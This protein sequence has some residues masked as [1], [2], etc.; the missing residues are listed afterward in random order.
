MLTNDLVPGTTVN[1]SM[2]DSARG[3]SCAARRPRHVTASVSRHDAAAPDRPRPLGRAGASP[4]ACA[5]LSKMKGSRRALSLTC[6]MHCPDR[7]ILR[8]SLLL[9]FTRKAREIHIM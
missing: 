6:F 8:S 2:Q 5:L 7:F 9:R 4:S 1:G 3:R